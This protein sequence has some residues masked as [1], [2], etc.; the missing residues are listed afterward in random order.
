M[1]NDEPDL[2]FGHTLTA[3][4]DP[5]E[6]MLRLPRIA[7]APLTLL[8]GKPHAGQPAIRLTAGFHVVGSCLSMVFGFAFT[9]AAL[10]L[11]GVWSGLCVIGVAMTLHGMR[12]ARMMVFHQAAHKNLY[13]RERLDRAIGQ[14]CSAIL[15]VQNFTQYSR[16]HTAEHHSR[17]H[18]TLRD[19]TV[20]AFLV[21]LGLGPGMSRPV[22]WRKVLTKLCSPVFHLSFAVG[23]VRSF[24]SGSTRA[25]KSIAVGFYAIAASVATATGTWPVLV[26]GWMIPLF[27]L[28]QISNTLRLCVK[29]TFPEP[30]CEDITG[31]TRMASLTNAIFIGEAVPD[32]GTGRRRAAVGWLHWTFRMIAIHAPARYLVLT[33]DTVCHDFHHR[34]PRHKLWYDYISE[35]QMDSDTAGSDWP[36]YTEVWGL[37]QAIGHV[38]DSLGRADPEFYDRAKIGSVSSRAVFAAFDD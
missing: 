8:T 25:E 33:G 7:Q 31:K 15:L 3:T 27:P 22:M 9:A 13:R 4:D 19:P 12:N 26:V 34:Y 37:A 30:G 38:F 21:G 23:R 35:R 28:F 1:G 17:H 6:S 36:P 18:M 11:G 20:Q 16:E 5:R 29:H 10:S 32:R 2:A 24:W 14:A